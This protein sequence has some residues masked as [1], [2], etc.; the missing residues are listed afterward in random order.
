DDGEGGPELLGEPLSLDAGDDRVTI[1]PQDV[2]GNAVTGHA[3]AVRLARA[4]ESPP[5][6]PDHLMGMERP[7]PQE[8]PHRPRGGQPY[9][10]TGVAASLVGQPPFARGGQ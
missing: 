8:S 7:G 1:R 10:A 3:L 4:R 9:Q 5:G 6:G 2:G